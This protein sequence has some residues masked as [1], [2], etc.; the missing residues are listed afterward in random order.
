A[1]AP[2]CR[3]LRGIPDGDREG[4]TWAGGSLPRNVARRGQTRD[5][6]VGRSLHRSVGCLLLHQAIEDGDGDLGALRLE[7]RAG[8]VP[9]A[10]TVVDDD[11]GLSG[12]GI[13]YVT[14]HEGLLVRAGEGLGK[15][16]RSGQEGELA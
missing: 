5:G 12:R 10:R 2:G 3:A 16:L 1:P 4:T 7:D 9:A 15:G 8:G 11:V 13:D 6:S 14:D